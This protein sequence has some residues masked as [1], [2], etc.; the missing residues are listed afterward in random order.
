VQASGEIFK[1]S[2]LIWIYRINPSCS[3]S[4]NLSTR[5]I[6]LRLRVSLE[7][8]TADDLHEGGNSLPD[9]LAEETAS[10]SDDT[11]PGRS[12]FVLESSFQ[13]GPHGQS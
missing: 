11:T 7:A 4:E 1:D 10:V 9:H 5:R 12:E 13:L 3:R 8:S 2:V 6:A